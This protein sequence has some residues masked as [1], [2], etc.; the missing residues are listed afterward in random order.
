MNAGFIGLGAMGTGMAR[1]LHAAGLL[2]AV[3]NRTAE[4]AQALAGETGCAIA[5]DPADLARRCEVVVT[6]V[7]ADEDVLSV[8]DQLRPGLGSRSI[9]VDCS[10][11]AAATAVAAGERVAAAGGRFLDC[12]VSGGTEGAAKGALA[13]MAGGDGEALERAMPALEAMGSRIVHIGEV[14]TGQATKAVNQIMAAG[15]N[16]AVSEA[17]AFG[18]AMELPMDKVID[19][20]GG[21]AAGNW[22]LSN[23]GPNMV[24]SEFSPGFKLALHDKD[25]AICQTMAADKGAQLPVIE[26]TRKQ[27]QRLIDAGHGD[28]DISALYRAKRALF[29]GEG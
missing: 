13:I 25:L 20:V 2:A 14:G 1:N 10:T 22:F 8:V 9:V 18:E 17:L 3:Y 12:P 24:R 7:S 26:M 29:S 16:Q 11:V 5:A 27:Y 6:C 15:I 19:A 28:E 21:G 4:R 23:R